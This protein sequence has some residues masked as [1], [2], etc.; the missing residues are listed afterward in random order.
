MYLQDH[1][2]ETTYFETIYGAKKKK[3][4][5]SQGKLEST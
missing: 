2:N 5:K 4:R 1:G 3:E